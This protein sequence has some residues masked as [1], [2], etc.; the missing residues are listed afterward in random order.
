MLFAY[1][2]AVV[3]SSQERYCEAGASE[4]IDEIDD[5][6][7]RA[8]EVLF[9]ALEAFLARFS[10]PDLDWHFRRTMNN[11]RGTLLFS[12]SR[13]HRGEPSAIDVLQWLAR[14]GPGSYGL[15]YLH[16]DEDDKRTRVDHRNEFRVWR[17]LRGGI[18]ELSDPF[19]SPIVPN[20]NPNEIA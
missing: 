5:E 1:G 14:E 8:D 17:L 20:I 6:V 13:N 15:V 10:P 11:A 19:L 16:D 18:D 7:D 12:S 4:R 2:W 9:D 3:R